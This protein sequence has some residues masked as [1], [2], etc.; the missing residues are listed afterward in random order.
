MKISFY[1]QEQ[2]LPTL[3]SYL[4]DPEEGSTL[5][6]SNQPQSPLDLQV[7][8]GYLEYNELIDL[9]LLKLL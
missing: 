5:L 2:D 8:I 6:I 4:E 7:T 1:I 9:E 3:Y